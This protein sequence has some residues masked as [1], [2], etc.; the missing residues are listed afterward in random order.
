MNHRIDPQSASIGKARPGSALNGLTGS[1]WS[2]VGENVVLRSTVRALISSN[3]VSGLLASCR[4]A[5]NVGRANRTSTCND[6]WPGQQC[7]R[8]V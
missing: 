5:R 7:S 6:R 3:A 8:P 4:C 1:Y 2:P